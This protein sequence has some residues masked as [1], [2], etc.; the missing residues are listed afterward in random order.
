MS[1]GAASRRE[2][3]ITSA[4]EAANG[5]L[6]SVQDSGPGIDAQCLDRLFDPFFTTKTDGLGMGLAISHSLIEAHG[7]RLWAASEE[8]QGATFHFSLPC[9]RD[10]EA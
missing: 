6:V 5:V 9:E 8:G 4:V 7:G 2:L 1:S 10:G 3:T